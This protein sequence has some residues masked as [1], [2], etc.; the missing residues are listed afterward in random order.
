MADN[1]DFS[2]VLGTDGLFYPSNF[3]CD[4][5]SYKPHGLQ[6]LCVTEDENGEAVEV[7]ITRETIKGVNG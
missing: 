4:D 3:R 1:L 7:P 2:L 6:L 5:P